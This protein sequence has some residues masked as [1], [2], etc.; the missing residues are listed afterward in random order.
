MPRPL[1]PAA[2]RGCWLAKGFSF[3]NR[4]VAIVQ[5]RYESRPVSSAVCMLQYDTSRLPEAHMTSAVH[6]LCPR[7]RLQNEMPS[8]CGLV[9]SAL[10][11][12]RYASRR[13]PKAHSMPVMPS[14]FIKPR[15]N[16][17]ADSQERAWLMRSNVHRAV[18]AA[19]RHQQAA[20][21]ALDADDVDPQHEDKHDDERREAHRDG[22]TDHQRQIQKAGV[23]AA[24][25]ACAAQQRQAEQAGRCAAR[26]STAPISARRSGG[27]KQL[28]AWQHSS[29]RKRL[30]GWHRT[31]S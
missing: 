28:C 14:T 30:S 16:I 25:C 7:P 8:C 31:S 24:C 22:H 21:G 12:L 2:A 4:S 6:F 9:T 11:M 20:K 5:V 19:V 17:R 27:W 15:H 26:H 3:S 18:H 10:C 1:L 29:A 23:C 13:L